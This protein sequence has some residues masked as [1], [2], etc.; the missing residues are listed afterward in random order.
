MLGAAGF[1]VNARAVGQ[2]NA[3]NQD[4]RLPA[5]LAAWGAKALQ[6]FRARVEEAVRLEGLRTADV[7]PW[8][9]IVW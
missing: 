6:E 5:D 1:A 4:E 9:K 2:A 7:P 3:F 8:G